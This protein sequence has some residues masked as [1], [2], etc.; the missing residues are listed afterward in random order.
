MGAMKELFHDE[1]CKIA[2]GEEITLDDNYIMS[3]L[4]KEGGLSDEEVNRM[5]N[6]V[7]SDIK[8]A[9]LPSWMHS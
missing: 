3:K 8:N 2:D 9:E 1:I 6:E 4:E 7:Q 5:Y